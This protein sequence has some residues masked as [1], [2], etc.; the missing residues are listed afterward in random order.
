ML[1]AQDALKNRQ[2]FSSESG[3]VDHGGDSVRVSNHLEAGA[4]GGGDSLQEIAEPGF[5]GVL[6][7][8]AVG[9]DCAGERDLRWD[10]VVALAGRGNARARLI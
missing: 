7:V 9:T 6:N 5:N 1:L 10:N 4:C 3:V 8:G 2:G